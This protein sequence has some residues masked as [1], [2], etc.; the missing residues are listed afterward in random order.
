MKGLKVRIKV[1]PV[2]MF[3]VNQLTICSG[4]F[5]SSLQAAVWNSGIMHRQ[6]L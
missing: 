4:S 1:S 2:A 6:I 5:M 3:T